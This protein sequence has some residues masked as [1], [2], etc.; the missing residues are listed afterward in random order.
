MR[1]FTRDVGIAFSAVGNAYIRLRRKVEWFFVFLWQHT[2][3]LRA[4]WL[5]NGTVR[6]SIVILGN[7]SPSG[8]SETDDCEMLI[9]ITE[10]R[11]GRGI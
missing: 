11:L 5:M 8:I 10:I 2:S 9:A 4:V 3:G 7:V 1:S 6:T